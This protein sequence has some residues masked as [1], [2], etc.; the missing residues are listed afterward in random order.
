MARVG[1]PGGYQDIIAA[2]PACLTEPAGKNTEA[3]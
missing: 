2:A 1:S 3:Y